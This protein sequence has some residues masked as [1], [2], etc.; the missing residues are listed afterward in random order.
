MIR[1]VELVDALSRAEVAGKISQIQKAHSE[2]DQRQVAMAMKD[3]ITV[4]AEKTQE[5]E[6]TDSVI[7]NKDKQEQEKNKKNKK[8]DEESER[9][10]NE[11]EEQPPLE[12]LDLKA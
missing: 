3:K 9:D 5:L 11:D 7:I 6:K 1:P 8:E 2:M 12:H 4:D 10:E